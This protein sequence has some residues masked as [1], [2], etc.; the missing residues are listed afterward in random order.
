MG[1]TQCVKQTKAKT[2]T[3]ASNSK[4]E[5]AKLGN[6]QII[7]DLTASSADDEEAKEAE[8][9]E[10]CEELYEAAGKCKTSHGFEQGIVDYH[11]CDNQVRNEKLVCNYISNLKAGHYDQTG[12]II[13][14]GG[15]TNLGGGATTT[16]GQ[17]FALTFFVLGT[18]G[19]AGYVF[20][21]H[22]QLTKGATADLAQQGGTIA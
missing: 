15:R 19:I 5:K 8:I 10:M 17:K 3:L 16:G 18:V 6:P 11:K 13:V 20:M 9:N 4:E 1:F 7:P 21:L 14:S 22:Q 12:E 2:P